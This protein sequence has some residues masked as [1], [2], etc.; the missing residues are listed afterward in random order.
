M[1]FLIAILVKPISNLFYQ[2]LN[3]SKST[4]KMATIMFWVLFMMGKRSNIFVMECL[5]CIRKILHVNYRV[6]LFGFR[7]TKTVPKGLVT[8]F[9]TKMQTVVKALRL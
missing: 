2:I 9:P 7:L 1:T 8:G 3:G 6:I 5:E 4:F